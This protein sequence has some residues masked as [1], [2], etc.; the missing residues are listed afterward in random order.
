MP[1]AAEGNANGERSARAAESFCAGGIAGGL[2]FQRLAI[3][4]AHSSLSTRL[5]IG[6]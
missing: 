1:G 4:R 2:M 6:W 3:R 5:K